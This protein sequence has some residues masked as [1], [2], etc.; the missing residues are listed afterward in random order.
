[1]LAILPPF[2][3]LLTWLVLLGWNQRLLYDISGR[4]ALFLAAAVWGAWLALS[5][6]LL[7]WLHAISFAGLLAAW[8]LPLVFILAVPGLRRA[9]WRGK[10]QLLASLYSLRQ[11]SRLE[12]L[13]VVGLALEAGLLLVV[14]WMAPPN[15]ND[16]MQYHLARV[17][18]WLQDGSLA[19]YPTAIDRQL[20]QPPWAELAI[21]NLMGLAGSDRWANLVQ[22]AAFIGAWIGVSGLA[23]SL[24]AS[25]KGQLLAI[26]VCATLPMG[27]LQ[28]TASQNDLVAAFWAVGV[29]FIV[30]KAHRQCV[31]SPQRGVAGLTW[32]EWVGLSLL[33]GLG[34]LTKG[35]FTVFALQALAWLLVSALRWIRA[36]LAKRGWWQLAGVFL[37]GVVLVLLLNGSHWARNMQTYGSPFGP[38]DAQTGLTNQPTG[39]AGTYSNLLRNIA[40]EA[41]TPLGVVNSVIDGAV[42]TLHAWV[43]L[44]SAS[45]GFTH[46][47]GDGGFFI[48]Y[49]NNNEELAGYLLHFLL[50]VVV[51]ASVFIQRHLPSRAVFGTVLCT[52]FLFY[53]F[54]FRWQPW[55]NRL[56]LPLYVI[57]SALMGAWLEGIGRFG[58]VLVAPLLL[59]AALPA[60]LTNTSRPVLSIQSTP[61]MSLS[62]FTSSRGELQF[63]NSP[64]F[65]NPWI[66]L[67]VELK[68]RAPQCKE[69]GYWIG[70]GEPEYALWTL[71][72]PDARVRR[73]EYVDVTQPVNAI[74]YPLGDFSPCAIFSSRF[75]YNEGIP[76]YT[77]VAHHTGSQL[78][79]RD[80]NKP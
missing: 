17:M 48:Q 7:G 24:D 41:A 27:I 55:G 57:G 49:S 34:V 44:D 23:A 13:L 47:A 40:Q 30:V 31:H 77:L 12:T 74:P 71:F 11:R 68:N 64:D 67:S 36:S 65:Y 25:G 20:W 56:V 2:I 42:D 21:L 10:D 51:L 4:L 62:V 46:G 63:A 8:L 33:V 61:E 80:E 78:Y 69:I 50:G 39:V 73:L 22:W 43:G 32:P 75:D 45:E 76:G 58:R 79:L 26:W 15:T 70:S 6:E 37:L 53:C 60:L 66:S 18:H 35:T 19:H 52:G 3:L 29:W 38:R 16:A 1:M 54:L 59:V 72:S 5:S 28:A 14:A 9:L